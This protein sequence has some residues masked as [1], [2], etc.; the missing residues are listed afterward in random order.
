[1]LPN[2]IFVGFQVVHE[3]LLDILGGLALRVLRPFSDCFGSDHD[4]ARTLAN[5]PGER[6]NLNKSMEWFCHGLLLWILNTISEIFKVLSFNKF[7]KLIKIWNL[8]QSFWI[9]FIFKISSIGIEDGD[10]W[11]LERWYLMITRTWTVRLFMS[12]ATPN[13]ARDR[14]I[15]YII[16]FSRRNDLFRF[17]FWAHTPR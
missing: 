2:I 15:R 5:Y 13:S 17:S 7:G 10:F 14:I 3:S 6:E 11:C 16:F 9:F 12:I 1:M 8:I 4:N